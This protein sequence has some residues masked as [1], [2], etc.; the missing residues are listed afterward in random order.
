M[1]WGRAARSDIRRRIA[2]D[3]SRCLTMAVRDRERSHSDAFR[4]EHAAGLHDVRIGI[5]YI[6]YDLDDGA[7]CAV[8]DG[9][10]ASNKKV[11]MRLL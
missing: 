11:K 5:G 7:T 6:E 9:R 10:G 4:L 3:L 8:R 2:I 1:G